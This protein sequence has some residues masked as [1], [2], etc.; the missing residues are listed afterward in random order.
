MAPPAVKDFSQNDFE[1]IA[2]DGYVEKIMIVNNEQ[3]E[4]FIKKDRVDDLI[5]MNK[6][7][8]YIK[9]QK[10]NFGPAPHIVYTAP[11]IKYFMDQL[12]VINANLAENGQ[13][14]VIFNND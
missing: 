10:S 7:Y 5:A 9:K 3:I 6:K 12:H 8:E 14:K 1:Q 11:E 13:P 4:V 2:K